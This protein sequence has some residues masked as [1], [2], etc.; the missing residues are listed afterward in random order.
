MFGVK[1]VDMRTCGITIMNYA[2]YLPDGI[3]PN[4]EGMELMYKN[5]L[6]KNY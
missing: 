4:A 6:N 2:T 3:H 5:I 1:W